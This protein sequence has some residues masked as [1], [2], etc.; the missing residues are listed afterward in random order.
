LSI[1]PAR[2]HFAG[3]LFF[4]CCKRSRIAA[5]FSKCNVVKKSFIEKMMTIR[6]FPLQ[7]RHVHQRA[8]E[9][10]FE[11]AGSHSQN[12]HCGVVRYDKTLRGCGFKI[13]PAQNRW[14]L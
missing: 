10:F 9:M 2:I 12:E 5:I 4:S 3:F 7:C 11:K 14:L 8:A 13:F 6:H 1:L